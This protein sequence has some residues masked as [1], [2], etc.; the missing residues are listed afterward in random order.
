MKIVDFG[1]SKF[2][3]LSGVPKSMTRTGAVVGT[4][5]YMSPEQVKGGKNIDNRSDLY[6]EGVVMFESVTGQLPFLADS[7][8]ELMFKIALE[9]PLDPETACP[10][11]DPWFAGILRKATARDMNERFQTA[12]EFAHA[13][14]EW[15]QAAQVA[16]L[17]SRKGSTSF[18]G[19][20][21]AHGS[22]GG[23][24]AL[25]PSGTAAVKI[26]GA[27]ESLGLEKTAASGSVLTP[28]PTPRRRS[29]FVAAIA[30]VATVGA[31]IVGI[32][33]ARSRSAKGPPVAAAE[34]SAAPLPEPPAIHSADLAALAPPVDTPATDP[35]APSAADSKASVDANAHAIPAN[36]A[37]VAPVRPH[38]VAAAPIAPPPVAAPPSASATNENST[39]IKGRTI[40]TEL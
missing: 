8:N 37:P 15:M 26:S 14:A 40:R 4:P 18:S 33:V 12:A 11:L 19:A 5:Y 13:I 35:P 38:P 16:P 10:G 2:T 39:T 22:L 7:F 29:G 34:I 1:V 24:P 32:G 36:H 31:V 6:S 28:N 30:I 23:M 3:S 21:P 20:T 25:T 27:V 9:A 17:P